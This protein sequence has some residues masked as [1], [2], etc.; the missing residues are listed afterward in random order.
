MAAIQFGRALLRLAGNA[1]IHVFS[2]CV[3]AFRVFLQ[4]SKNYTEQELTFLCILISRTH[5][6]SLG[7]GG[8]VSN[9]IENP[10]VIHTWAL[11]IV[12]RNSS[13]REEKVFRE[14]EPLKQWNTSRSYSNELGL[15]STQ[16]PT[17]QIS[18]MS[19]THLLL[20]KSHKT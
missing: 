2:A 17:S 12:H 20:I 14:A 3:A 16:T 5:S 9:F 7:N 8:G 19:S 11:L 13:S 4:G 10:I 6:V 1:G 18:A 15:D